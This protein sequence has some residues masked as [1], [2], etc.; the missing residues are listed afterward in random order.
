MKYIDR[1]DDENKKSAE[2]HFDDLRHI[3]EQLRAEFEQFK[4]D[5]SSLHQR[6]T[7]T[8]KKIVELF[9]LIGKRQGPA[10]A[11]KDYDDE[12]KRLNDLFTV[13]QGDLNNLKIEM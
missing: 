6:V 11:G 4:T 8:E 9:A 7:V 3:N 13:M 10:V 2:K 5:F 12:I 1:G